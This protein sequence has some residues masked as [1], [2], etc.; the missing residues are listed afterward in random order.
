MR[1]MRST[2]QERKQLCWERHKLQQEQTV[3]GKEGARDPT[4]QVVARLRARS[5]TDDGG[6][7]PEGQPELGRR[8]PD[9]SVDSPREEGERA[10]AREGEP[11]QNPKQVSLAYRLSRSTFRIAP[12]FVWRIRMSARP[13]PSRSISSLAI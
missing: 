13:S 3:H 5:R 6:Q 12:A 11:R 9:P 10:D 2:R 7:Q 4:A 1:G 8:N